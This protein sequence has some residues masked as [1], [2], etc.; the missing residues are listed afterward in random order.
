VKDGN[1]TVLKLSLVLKRREWF[2]GLWLKSKQFKLPVQ[3]SN[4]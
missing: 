1:T 3:F 4:A 2:S